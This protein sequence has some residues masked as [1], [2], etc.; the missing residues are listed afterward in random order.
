LVQ[1]ESATE[2][3]RNLVIRCQ[4]GEEGAF[5]EL[6][7]KY[8]QTV[9]NL[10]YHSIGNR[11]DVE[12]IAQKVFSKVYFSLGKFD[13]KRPFFPWLYR[14]A[15]NQ[16]YDELRR[17]KRRKFFTFTDLSLE[18]E[19]IEKLMNQGEDEPIASED[20]QELYA[21]L[22]RMLDSF[23]HSRKQRSCCGI[24]NRSHTRK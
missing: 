10:I 23:R 6:V 16:C 14:I 15:V 18:I 3:D 9:F 8:Q 20:R 24:W 11:L 21:L 13:N 4:K 1:S 22:H 7:R 2:D 19:S 5:E 12:D 17:L